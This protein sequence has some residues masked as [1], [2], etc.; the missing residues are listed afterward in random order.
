[1]L[2]HIKSM[3]VYTG[4]KRVY[5][6]YPSSE[7]TQWE[8]PWPVYQ[9][10]S[11]AVISSQIATPLQ[12]KVWS[13]NICASLIHVPAKLFFPYVL[14]GIE[15]G[16]HIG[17]HYAEYHCQSAICRQHISVQKLWMSTWIKNAP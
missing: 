6:A 13:K 1:M 7:G 10:S 4:S 14:P 11:K 16:F 12:A 8:M 9:L 15:E 3:H 5:E 2:S 17:F